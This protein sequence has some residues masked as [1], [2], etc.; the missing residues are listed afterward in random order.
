MIYHHDLSPWLLGPFT[1]GHF[2][3][4]GIRW[5]AL[6]YIFGFLAIYLSL[7]RAVVRR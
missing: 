5:Y 7:Y 4:I 1:I 3:Q 6:A 2:D